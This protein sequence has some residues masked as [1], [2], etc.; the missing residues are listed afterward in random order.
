M[1]SAITKN[2]RKQ[3]KLL[4]KPAYESSVRAYTLWQQNPY[5]PSLHFKR[6]S[7]SEPLYSVRISLQY[8]ALGLLENDSISWFWIGSHSEYDELLKRM[9]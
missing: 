5:H 1:K 2:F 3:L 4:P 6:V 8:R 9:R 7:R